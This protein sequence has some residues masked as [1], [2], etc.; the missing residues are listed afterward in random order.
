MLREML[1]DLSQARELAWRLF[2]RDLKAQF[3]NSILGYFWVFIPPLMAALPFVYLNAQGVV[4][5]GSTPIPYGAYAMTGT[6][7]WQVFVDALNSPLK[8][9]TS[10]R[11]MLTRINFP[12]EAILIAALLQTGFGFGIRLLLLVAV[13]LWFRVVPAPTAPLFIIG[14]LGLILTGF[15]LGLLITPLGLLYGDVSQAIP[16]ATTM[17]MFLTPVLY[18]TPTDGLAATVSAFNPLTPL[19]VATRD[20]LT[21]GATDYLLG[22]VVVSSTAVFLLLLGWVLYRIALPHL[23]ARLG[24]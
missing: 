16:V 24:N 17:L 11:S 7:I 18:P 8:S 6:I 9:V 1:R 23:V 20:W 2:I 3:R 5:M 13:F 12:R 4:S 14:I 19:V 21:I 15:M 22:F 10:A